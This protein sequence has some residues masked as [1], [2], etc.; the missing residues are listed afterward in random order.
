VTADLY[1]KAPITSA[2]KFEGKE[3][4]DQYSL[5]YSELVNSVLER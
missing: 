1:E 4:R 3:V 5:A 2:P